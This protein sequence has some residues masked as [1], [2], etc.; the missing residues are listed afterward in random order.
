MKPAEPLE[1]ALAALGRPLRLGGRDAL[2]LASRQEVLYLEAGKAEIFFEAEPAAEHGARRL[3]VATLGK[4][5]FAFGLRFARSE[6]HFLPPGEL[7][8][9]P[10]AGSR[11]RTLS[12]AEVATLARQRELAPA[13]VARVEGWPLALWRGVVAARPPRAAQELV[14]GTEAQ[15]SSAGLA[16]RGGS[17]LVW[18]RPL[19]GRCQLLGEAE[20]VVEPGNALLPLAD[21]T[22]LVAAEPLRLSCVA[23]AVLLA[24]GGLWEGLASFHGELLAA[25]A[26]NNRRRAA[27]EREEARQRLELDRRLEREAVRRLASVFRP[28][29]GEGAAADGLDSPLLAACR[30][31]AEAQGIALRRPLAE[32]SSARP[33]R[34]VARIAEASRVRLRRVILKGDWW[35]RDNGP[36]VAFRAG[37]RPSA[38]A[39]APPP[40]PVSLLPRPGGGYRLVD[41]ASGGS[42]PLDENLAGALEPAA[43]MFYPPLPER[44]LGAV[45]LLRP[46]LS[47]RGRD[48]L[49]LALLGA[50]GGLLSLLVPVLTGQLFGSVIPAAD[51]GRLLEATLALA[52]AAV[53]GAGFQLSRSVAVLRLGARFDGTV[54]A[55]VWD[56]L[57]RLPVDFF[58]R[59][60]V[61]DLAD[62]AHGIDAIRDLLAGR[63]T[64][65]LLASVFSLASFALLFYY[66][67]SLALVATA[68]VAGLAA[69]T[70]AL[71]ALQLRH[72]RRAVGLRG[73]LASLLFGLIR[74][75]AKLQ[76]A[77]A[78]SRAF[79]RWAGHFAEQRRASLAAQRVAIVQ[80]CFSAAY[81]VLSSLSL[82]AMVELTSRQE[83]PLA[84][85]LAFNTAFAQFQ[86]A[87]L[88]T[89]EI[90]PVVLAAI[91][92]YERLR[93]IVETL[94]EVEQGKPEVGELAGD[95]EMSHVSFRY[96]PH[97]PLVLD[98]VSFRARPGEMVALVGPSGSGKSTC[99]RLL[100]GFDRPESGSL[101]YDGQD[102]SLLD[103]A[104]LRRQL[105]VVLQHGRPMAGDLFTNIVGNRELG[106]DDAWEAAR[107][108][109]LAEDIEAMPMKMH[110]VV[111]EG[112]G[113]F[114]GGQ[115]QRL[116]IARALVHRPRVLFFDEATSALDNPTQERVAASLER[117][118]VTR[119]VIAH[120]LSTIANAHRIY[121]LDRGRMVESGSFAELLE[122]G[123]LFARLAARQSLGAAAR[124]A[125][126]D[127]P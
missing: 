80:A 1:Q 77:G 52:L 60:P 119:V 107:M 27:A 37:P 112:A 35:G 73:E 69:V 117:L 87:A 95:V 12:F 42:E 23:G 92:T 59:F 4:G 33:E 29:A 48:L 31:A 68:L 65:A 85:F 39:P 53:A 8:L 67:R 121:V 101:Y 16:A 120:R 72:Q 88:A 34:Q 104:S 28:R 90:F 78:E 74:G 47:G 38:Q 91:P 82:F 58:R 7:L 111:S 116:M 86:A 45:D 13:L 110:T 43:F 98:D 50:G 11:L 20:L 64:S 103:P 32:A 61:G 15:L 94:P 75:V 89:I 126:G 127:L 36:L 24:G 76:V 56:R 6:E 99:L 19:A 25:L 26:L 55:A 3:P 105:G 22:W 10:H 46:V 63:V 124:L 79:A 44:S 9:V 93:P 106:L 108:A 62:R 14:A 57:L 51:R 49:F 2:G 71:A 40:T 70:V 18:A 102:L 123:G 21:F 5:S 97:G 41:P 125:P 122:A 17:G 113:T 96:G 54:Q 100:L 81:G 109:G 30:L 115:I 84:E 114:S 118:N 66:S 83:L